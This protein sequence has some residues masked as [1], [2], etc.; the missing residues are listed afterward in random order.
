M[1]SRESLCFVVHKMGAF[2]PAS[3]EGVMK[4]RDSTG[5]YLVQCLT[6]SELRKA[7]QLG[8]FAEIATVP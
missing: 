4:K 5:A 8:D 7:H 1:T 2:V 3:R 6:R